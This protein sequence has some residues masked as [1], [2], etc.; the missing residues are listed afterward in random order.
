MSDSTLNKWLA[1]G[2]DTA[3]G[4]FTPDPPMTP[5]DPEGAHLWVN[6][7]DPVNPALKWWDG[8]A[9]V[10]LV[11]VGA[12]AQAGGSD[13]EVQFNNAGILD[14]I[15][16]ATTDGTA[17]TLV[18]PVLGTPAS[19]NLS[20]CTALPV[21]TGI[22]GLGTG[23]A[24]FLA[25]P[26]SANLATAVTGETGSGALVFATSPTLVTP[27]LGTPTALVLTSATGT[28]TSIGLANGTG[29]PVATGISG[30]G[31]G[32]ADFLATPSSA[33]LATAVTGETGSGALVFGTGPTLSAPVLG[34]PASGTLT[35]CTGL[36]ATGQ[37]SSTCMVKNASDLTGQDYT[38]AAAITWDTEIIDDNGYHSGGAPSR[39]TIPSG[40]ARVKLGANV[41]LRNVSANVNSS[42]AIRKG[43]S[44]DWDGAAG[45]DV[46]TPGTTRLM[47]CVT[48]VVA[49]SATEFFE[50]YITQTTDTSVDVD[51][52]RSNFWLEVVS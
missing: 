7:E 21:A 6:K 26:S 23:V 51:A 44:A 45:Q 49:V 34:T 38:T 13:T 15:T 31:T 43:G 32:V 18:A 41:L 19:G 1:E 42:I 28:P 22:S 33:N 17:L 11:T 52:E 25:T 3:E 39:I 29:L 9:W 8:S 50:V 35:N 5:P 4:A 10:T 27:A 14:G 30:L 2:D 47:S 12:A 36:P 40:I 37:V 24:D 16:G 46:A 20:N 48:G